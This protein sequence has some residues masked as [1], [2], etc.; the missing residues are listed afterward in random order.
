MPI[1]PLITRHT[2]W[3]FNAAALAWQQARAV[4]GDWR[5]HAIAPGSLARV[6]W[7]IEHF[8]RS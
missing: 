8:H 4:A 7:L 1:V 3:V 6:W 2:V 5:G